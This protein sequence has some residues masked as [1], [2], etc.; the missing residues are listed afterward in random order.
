MQRV[1]KTGS[2]LV[3]LFVAASVRALPVATID[4]EFGLKP[5]DTPRPAT[6]K[7]DS[8][9]GSVELV[10]EMRT[11]GSFSKKF[12]KKQYGVRL[13]NPRNLTEN[14][15]YPMLGLPAAKDW[16]LVGN[17][18]D[19]SLMRNALAYE[20][21]RDMG[22]Y[23]PRTREFELYLNGDYRGIYTLTERLERDPQRLDIPKWKDG[24]FIVKIDPPDSNDEFFKL[25]HENIKFLYDYPEADVAETP[26]GARALDAIH[27]LI[28]S[29]EDKLRS[30]DFANPLTGYASVIDVDSFVDFM[31]VQELFNNIDAYCRSVHFHGRGD[32]KLVAGPLWDF[33]IG[34]GNFTLRDAQKTS[35][36]RAGY[37]PLLTI[38]DMFSRS[39]SWFD[40]LREDP[41]FAAR[42]KA[43]W[44]E[45]RQSTFSDENINAIIDRKLAEYGDAID[46][47][48]ERW[49]VFG[50]PDRLIRFLIYPAPWS[51]DY[52]DEITKMR[53]W[54]Q[55]RAAWIDANIDSFYKSDARGR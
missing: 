43:R 51:K 22:H 40:R 2:A 33:D 44:I 52:D 17:F 4:T 21:G 18:Q 27:N 30:P 14:S 36:W 31:L 47:N 16:S 25:R 53:A 12:P 6:M 37:R 8:E 46:R 45:L 24:G 3:C 32:G 35:G 5:N 1:M 29:V 50:V 20:L 15:T 41:A 7:L 23:A 54:F 49:D 13:K 11:R 55:E 42:A 28:W 38:G 48:F 19:R 10:M 34:A 26:E 39:A 9:Q